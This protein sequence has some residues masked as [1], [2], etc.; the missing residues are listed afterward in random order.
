VPTGFVAFKFA[1][2]LAIRKLCSP[3][4]NKL[5]KTVLGDRL[6]HGRGSVNTCKYLLA[7]LSRAPAA[8]S[9]TTGSRALEN[10]DSKKAGR[11]AREQAVFAFFRTPKA[12]NR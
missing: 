6:P 10:I 7:I 8:H 5:R 12:R 1:E 11:V 2:Y 9:E 4:S 3:A